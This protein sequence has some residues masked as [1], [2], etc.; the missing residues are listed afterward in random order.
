MGIVIGETAEVGDDC[1]LYHG[2]TLGGPVGRR[3]SGIRRSATT[4]SSA[5]GAKVLGPVHVGEGA[6]IG[7][8]A[9]VTRDVP[10]GATMVGVPA[11]R[12][13]SRRSDEQQRRAFAERIGF[14][15]YGA[16]QDMPDPVVQ[17]VNAL[18]DHIRL[19]DARVEEMCEA[20]RKLGADRD[21]PPLPPMTDQEVTAI[22]S[23]KDTEE[24][25]EQQATER[26][27]TPGNS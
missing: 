13:R 10:P 12:A 21:L 25:Q 18:L 23:L 14:D 2:V 27:G 6:R 17:S 5:R 3:A 20:L 8:N 15:A 24:N 26:P 19:L 1:T 11:H 4:S 7:S 16:G 22:E 9:V